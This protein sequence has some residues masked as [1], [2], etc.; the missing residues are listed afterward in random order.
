M[1]NKC[2]FTPRKTARATALAAACLVG[3][4]YATP[5]ASAFDS[6]QGQPNT[7]FSE[8]AGG[9]A[10][11]T[12]TGRTSVQVEDPTRILKPTAR[13]SL[14]K[15]TQKIDF[16]DEVR[17]VT[18]IVIPGDSSNFNDQITEFLSRERPELLPD[19]RGEGATFA[20][21]SL[22]VAVGTE[23]RN[24]GIYCGND[25][26]AALDMFEGPHLNESL[27]RMKE[28]FKRNNFALGLLYGAQTAADL[29]LAQELQ[30]KKDN[31][32]KMTA[33]ALGGGG[34]AAAGGGVYFY[35]WARRRAIKTAREQ[36][37]TIS[38][39]YGDLA[40]RLEALDIRAHSLTSPLANAELRSQWESIRDDFLKLDQAVGALGL[41]L[42]STDKQFYS[43][44]HEIGKAHEV[45]ESMGNAEDNINVMFQLENGDTVVREREIREMRHDV[46]SAL[47]EVENDEAKLQLQRVSEQLEWLSNNLEAPN[48]MDELARA[49]SDQSHAM[50]LAA[51]D[52]KHLKMS[53]HSAPTLRDR[54]WRPGYSYS[55]W[56]PWYLLVSW[57]DSDT[58]AAQSSSGSSGTNTGFSGGF[59]GGGGS[60]SW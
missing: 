26:C 16:P 31:E 7:F 1:T 25:V 15:D 49:I 19:G 13:K 54:D 41:T 20:D 57:N 22:I 36:F 42:D 33:I 50:E 51:K 23:S 11:S 43:K 24:N 37:D 5:A 30:N 56:I 3:G 39:R 28:P 40:Q 27:E 60:S 52:M 34:V 46:S 35:R 55:D 14:M 32:Q 58:Q 45:I 48:F 2:A 29:E 8:S 21:G 44:R 18:Y 4:L 47:F 12:K 9:S 38:K 17:D 6:S 53:K 10:A 59:A